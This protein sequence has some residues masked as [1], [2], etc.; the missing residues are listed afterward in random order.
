MGLLAGVGL[1]QIADCVVHWKSQIG[2]GRRLAQTAVVALMA[3]SHLYLTAG[4]TLAAAARAPVLFWPTGVLAGVDWL[5]ENTSWEETVLAGF[6]TGSLIPARIGHRVVLGHWMETVD[7][8]AKREAVARF[9]TTDTPDE[10]RLTLL[11]EWGVA[12]LFCGPEER[13]LGDFDPSAV[14]YLEP[15]F[16]QGEV[17]VY[18]VVLE[19]EP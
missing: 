9:F 12:W 16:Q 17:A 10:E 6:E 3:V 8:E 18:R 14:T 7:F 2:R 19:R 5:G 11:R 1:A 15:V 4:A 13:S